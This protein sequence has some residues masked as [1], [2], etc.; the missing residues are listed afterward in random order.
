[1]LETQERV[2]VQVQ[3][4]SGAEFYSPSRDPILQDLSLIE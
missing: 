2:A 1:M 4:L 3:R